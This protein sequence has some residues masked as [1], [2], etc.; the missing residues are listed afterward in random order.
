MLQTVSMRHGEVGIQPLP[1]LPPVVFGHSGVF[2]GSPDWWR[3]FEYLVDRNR[4]VTHQEDLWTPGTF[5]L[6]L[7]PGQTQYLVFGLARL[8]KNPARDCMA[9]TCQALEALDPGEGLS[10]TARRLSVAAEQFRADLCERPGHHLGLSVARPR[11][12]RRADFP[13]GAVSGERS[14]RRGQ[15]RALRPCSA[16]RATA[17]SRAA[18]RRR[19]RCAPQVTADAS[20]W[21]FE[22]T[23][24]L[25]GQDGS[26]RRVRQGHSCT[27]RS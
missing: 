19:G 7:E 20:L 12:A 16:R 11:H 17:C 14:Y 5:E 21:L 25:L 1:D 10:L 4:G 3:R 26:G 24:R 6:D 8:P 2:M 13:A 15:A 9:E 18:F 27:R 22:A 23:A